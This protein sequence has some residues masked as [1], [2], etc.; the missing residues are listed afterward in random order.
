MCDKKGAMHTCNQKVKLMAGLRIEVSARIVGK[1]DAF[2]LDGCAVFWVVAWPSKGNIGSLI[3]NFR[4]Y[5]I[6]KSRL[7]IADVYHICD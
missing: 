6:N 5:V 2:F 7:K 4:K 3:E 1:P